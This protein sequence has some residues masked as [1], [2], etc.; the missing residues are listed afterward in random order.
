MSFNKVILLGNVAAA[1]EVRHLEGGSTVANFRLATSEYYKD[2]SGQ[3][4]EKVEWH[5]IVCWGKT[6]E[7]TEKYVQK[8]ASLLVDG[9][10]RTREYQDKSG[11]KRYVTEIAADILQ[12]AGAR[13]A[14]DNDMP[15]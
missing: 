6:A 2:R 14:N 15:M 7:W 8:G 10:L 12:F 13:K 4:T 5:N 9:K 11:N 3:T 1:P